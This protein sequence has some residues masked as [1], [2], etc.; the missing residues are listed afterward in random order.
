[1]YPRAG[2]LW[3]AFAS[4]EEADLAIENPGSRD[5]LR[6]CHARLE[7]AP[8]LLRRVGQLS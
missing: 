3:L 1:M 5:K 4:V 7:E 8:L 6:G 2:E